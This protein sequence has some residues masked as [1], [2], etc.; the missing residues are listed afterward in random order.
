[1]NTS[2]L[3]QTVLS[4]QT[5]TSVKYLKLVFVLPGTAFNLN[6]FTIMCCLP[7]LILHSECAHLG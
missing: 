5:F 2:N 1:M 3:G 4:V 7:F 6:F